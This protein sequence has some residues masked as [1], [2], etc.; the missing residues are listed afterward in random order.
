MCPGKKGAKAIIMKA[1]EELEKDKKVEEY[2]YLFN[3]VSEKKNVMNVATVKGRQFVKPKFEFPGACAGCGETA[4]LK[5]VTQLFGDRMVVAY[6]TGCSSIYGASSPSMPY[7]IPWAISLFEDNAELGFG[8]RIA[9]QAMKSRISRM[10]MNNIKVVKKSEQEIYKNYAEVQN[11]ENA[12][13][14]LE[15]IDETRIEGLDKLKDFIMPRSVWMIGGDGWAYD[16]G[17]NGIDHVLANKENVNIL[18]LDTEVYSNTG[19]QSSKSTRMGAV[20]KFAASGKET[21]KKDLA[22]IALTYPHVYVGTISMGA[23][24][25]QAIKVLKEAEAYNG[26]S[27][28]IAY[29]PCIAQGIIKGM[30]NS[31]QEEK[32]ATQSGYFPLFLYNPE[33]KQFSMDSQADFSKYQE[34]INGE[35]RYRSLNKLNKEAKEKLEENQKH[36]EDRYKYYQGLSNKKD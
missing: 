13:E 25:N 12:K 30:K 28:I 16:I 10:I 17:Y 4:Y 3:E 2:K 31:L 7:S 11:E 20:A 1:R 9:D 27:I 26:P 34:F 15:V 5:L 19:G 23:N 32:E 36:A 29:A 14:L 8:M 22:K 24:A 18:V 35:D 33:N 6:A 21:A